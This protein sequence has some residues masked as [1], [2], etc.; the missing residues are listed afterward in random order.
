M[1]KDDV[2]DWAQGERPVA[3]TGNSL[4]DI[5]GNPCPMQASRRSRDAMPLFQDAQ[6]LQEALNEQN[7]QAFEDAQNNFDSDSDSDGLSTASNEAQVNDNVSLPSFVMSLLHSTVPIGNLVHYT[8]PPA[9]HLEGDSEAEDADDGD[10]GTIIDSQMLS[11]FLNAVPAGG[12]FHISAN[13]FSIAPLQPPGVIRSKFKPEK[14]SG[15]LNVAL[16][17]VD[18][19]YRTVNDLLQQQGRD[20]PSQKGNGTTDGPYLGMSYFPHLGRFARTPW[21]AKKFL[22]FLRRPQFVRPRFSLLPRNT[23]DRA[24]R[25]R[26][27]ADPRIHIL[28]TYEK[29]VELLNFYRDRETKVSEYDCICQG[30]TNFGLF[31]DEGLRHHFHATSRLNMIAHVPELYIIVVGS[32]TGRVAIIT[33]TKKIQPKMQ[34]HGYWMHGFR[35]EWI[36]PTKEDEE[37]HRRTL[38]P[39]HGM[40]VGPVPESDETGKQR[41]ASLPRRYRLMLHYQNHDILSYELTREEQT[42]KVCIF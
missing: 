25:S 8:H 38:R 33:P 17:E 26:R 35:V 7:I 1:D 10:E 6:F 28:R 19:S 30:V 23:K 37:V 42:G 21:E 14:S 40:A 34:S 9:M 36:L 16:H 32:P 3:F 11:A 20:A 2:E 29:D 22:Q 13:S 24:L 31:Q 18:Q 15:D 5:P 4:R 12:S 39:L 27:H 41:G